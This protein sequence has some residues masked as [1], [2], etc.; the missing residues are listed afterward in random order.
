MAKEIRSLLQIWGR[1]ESLEK[2]LGATNEVRNLSKKDE[3]EVKLSKKAQLLKE[4]CI[5]FGPTGPKWAKIFSIIIEEDIPLKNQDELYPFIPY[6]AFIL[7][8]AEGNYQP[9]TILIALLPVGS[10]KKNVENIK[11]IRSAG[12]IGGAIRLSNRALEI[13]S[14]EMIEDFINATFNDIG[15]DSPLDIQ[16]KEG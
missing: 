13:A 15:D 7:K 4:H 2:V 1:K 8:V 3:R 11:G 16:G 6:S 5:S 14:N 9:G 12:D 10:G